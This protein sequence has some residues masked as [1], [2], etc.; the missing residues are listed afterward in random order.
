MYHEVDRVADLMDGADMVYALCGTALWE[1]PE[2]GPR[3]VSMAPCSRCITI[4]MDKVGAFG[5]G[6]GW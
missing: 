6:A 1:V 2:H 4:K 5:D 3:H